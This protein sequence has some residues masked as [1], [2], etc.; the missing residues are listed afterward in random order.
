MFFSQPSSPGPGKDLSL[1]RAETCLVPMH[2]TMQICLSLAVSFSHAVL[3]GLDIQI[4]QGRG[5]WGA[6]ICP[7]FISCSEAMLCREAVGFFLLAPESVQSLFS[8]KK[9]CY[10]PG[11]LS[12]FL[13]EIGVKLLHVSPSS[14]LRILSAVI[15]SS[16]EHIPAN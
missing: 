15:F 7:V 6:V 2:N 8:L 16:E 4:P 1:P 3:R 12:W 13:H 10:Y 14:Q 5:C 9:S 11:C